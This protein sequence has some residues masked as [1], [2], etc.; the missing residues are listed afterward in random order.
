[1]GR[2]DDIIERNRNPKRS[3]R[4]IVGIGV[5]IFLLL[6]LVLMTFTDLGIPSTGEDAP[7]PVEPAKDEKRVNDVK[8]R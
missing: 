8:L 6:I 4:T 7:A 1:M 2:L 5:A 3:E